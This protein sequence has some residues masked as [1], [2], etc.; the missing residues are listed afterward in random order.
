[1]KDYMLITD[2][3]GIQKITAFLGIGCP[4]KF[5]EVQGM[6]HTGNVNVIVAPCTPPV[7]P[8]PPVPIAPPVETPP[9]EE[10]KY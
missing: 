2:E 1:M 7:T 4:I 6:P 3:A 5:V 8:M 9:S 10:V